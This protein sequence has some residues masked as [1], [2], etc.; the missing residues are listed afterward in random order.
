MWFFRRFGGAAHCSRFLHHDSSVH[1]SVNLRLRTGICLLAAAMSSGVL[2]A[3]SRGSASALVNEGV[4]ALDAQRFGEALDAFTSASKLAPRNPEVCLGAGI[5]ATRLGRNDEAI[6]WFERALKLAPDFTLA[7]QWLGELQYREGHVKD[8]IS[9]YEAALKTSPEADVLEKRLV[10]WRKETQL[11][12]RF[13][14]SRGAHFVV[15]FEGPAD[16]A[17]ARRIVERL[18]QAYWRIGGVLTAYPSKPITVVLYTT[19]QF[20][21]I[22][23]MP[24]W[25]AA[26][27]D[28]RI[29][30][31]IKGGLADMDRLDRVLSHEFV[32]AVVATLGGRNVPAWLNEGLAVTL[33]AGDAEYTQLLARARTRPSLQDLHDGFATLS[34]G[35]VHLAYAV[36]ANAVKRLLALRGPYAVVG[37]MQ[38]MARGADFAG[39]FQQRFAMRYDDFQAMVARD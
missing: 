15:L 2:Q 7:S 39:A 23:R 29:R 19:E 12:D 30:L 24:A 33:E 21:D 38:D 10:D 34:G 28:G 25:T 9:T 32:H 17:L 4:A 37:V 35:D 16:D 11:Q 36:S 26:S 5:A 27:F 3:Q 31:P 6:D 14:E 8:A 1:V 18:E 20:R 22:T 13:Y